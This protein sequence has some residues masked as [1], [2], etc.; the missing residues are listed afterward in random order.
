M[1]F[2]TDRDLLPLEPGV[3]TDVPIAAQ[4]L[5]RRDQAVLAGGVLSLP[6]AD[7]ASL[8][9]DAG[10]VVL[11]DRVPH[12][13]IERVDG[14]AVSVSRL[15]AR[16]TDPP[17]VPDDAV[18]P[19]VVIR[20]FAPQAALVHDALLRLLGLDP[21]DPAQSADDAVGSLSLMAQLEALGTL[22]RV[23]SGAAAVTGDN[24]GL[25]L[26]ASAYRARFHAAL[27]RAAVRLDL[28]GA[29]HAEQ[30]RRPG[31]VRLSRV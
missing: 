15:R 19:A 24:A 8:G 13:V 14:G 1:N 26:K 22:E 4:L 29:G 11:I 23:Y 5:V 25:L 6:G 20:S 7:L 17:I 16:L 28:A 21:D 18:E 10:H 2:S 3:F 9:V 12:E 30:I 27:E 31:L